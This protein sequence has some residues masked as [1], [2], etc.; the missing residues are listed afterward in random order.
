MDNEAKL[1]TI[2]FI[3]NSNNFIFCVLVLSGDAGRQT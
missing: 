1:A 2:L 3:I